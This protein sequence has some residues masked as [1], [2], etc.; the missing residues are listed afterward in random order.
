MQA[1]QAHEESPSWDYKLLHPECFHS[2]RETYPAMSCKTLCWAYC[3]PED[4]SMLFLTCECGLQMAQ[5]V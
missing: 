4:T 2:S 3:Q 1:S 5:A